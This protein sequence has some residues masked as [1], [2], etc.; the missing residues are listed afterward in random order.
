MV[1]MVFKIPLRVMA[2]PHGRVNVPLEV[3]IDFGLALRKFGVEGVLNL[4]SIQLNELG[5]G[6]FLRR[7]P[8]QYTP[9]E[10]GRD[11]GFVSW[12]VKDMDADTFKDYEL[13]FDVQGGEVE[14]VEEFSSKVCLCRKDD[15]LIDI[16]I[17]GELFAT[18][19]Y[20]SHTPKPYLH[21]VYG[22]GGEPITWNS[23]KDHPHHHSIWIGYG[24][25]NKIDFW[26]EGRGSG[27]IVHKLFKKILEGP[28][29]AHFEE[30][31]FWVGP[32]GVKVLEE[33][34]GVRIYNL[35]SN[36]RIIDLKIVFKASEGDIV[37]QDTKEGG[38]LAVRVADFMDVDHGGRIQNSEGGVNEAQT[39]GR[40]AEWCDY[41]GFIRGVWRGIAIFNSPKNFRHP[42]YWHV[43]NYGLFCPNISSEFLKFLGSC[44]VNQGGE[45]ALNYRL[46]IHSGDALEGMVQEKYY[47]YV[48]PPKVIIGEPLRTVP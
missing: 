44:K 27:R 31:N 7:T 30:V 5:P 16:K 35:P 28:V 45:M 6:D 37:L 14:H 21:P 42:T 41:S 15:E 46:Y 19:N 13:S 12:I 10:G 43:R 1:S 25:I 8:F 11:R 22:P 4:N 38:P 2:G 36:G 17:G 26:G 33:D 9:D 48:D 40:K 24:A 20:G 18:Y 39:W 32:D 29:F 23:P 47:D 3:F 34:R